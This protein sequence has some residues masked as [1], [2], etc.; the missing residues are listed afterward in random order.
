[1]QYRDEDL[2]NN[3]YLNNIAQR[4]ARRMAACLRNAKAKGPWVGKGAPTY[5]TKMQAKLSELITAGANSADDAEAVCKAASEMAVLAH[6]F[7][8]VVLDETAAERETKRKDRTD[9]AR[10]AEKGIREEKVA[11]HL[12]DSR[13]SAAKKIAKKTTTKR[14]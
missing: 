8:D 1:M 13:A 10:A 3:G 11:K 6:M 14:K 2:K 9:K 4:W 12:T 7:C 5:A